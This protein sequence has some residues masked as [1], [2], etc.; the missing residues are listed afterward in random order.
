MK[1]PFKSGPSL[2]VLAAAAGLPLLGAWAAGRNLAPILRFPPNLAMPGGAPPFAWAWAAA[3]AAV[4]A[5]IAASWARAPRL[6]KAPMARAAGAR[7]PFPA[8][9][10]AALG[11]TGLAWILAWTRWT[12]FAP[13]Q[14]YTFFPLWLGFVVS[15]NAAT[16]R[17]TGRCLMLRRPRTWLALFAVSAGFWW[18]FEWLN[19][20]VD[21]WRYLGVERFGPAAYAFHATLCF[22][23]V[24]PAV[25]A[26]AEWLGSHP[27]WTARCAAGPAWTWLA[28]RDA[29]WLLLL[30]GI[31]A[32][33]FTGARPRQAYPALWTAPLA[34]ALGEG[35]LSRRPGTASEL[36]SGDWRRAGTW[37]A[38]ALLCGGFWE[39]WN[40]GSLAHWAYAVPYVD[41]WHLFA[42]PALG[43][44]GYLPFGLECLEICDRV[45]GR[46]RLEDA[47]PPSGG[48][49][50]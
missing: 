11:W 28:R 8:W 9:G 14:A 47:C 3:V 22:S 19:R 50:V 38:A 10:W 5:A 40:F 46:D 17:R 24:L 16:W 6:R 37:A 35:I 2:A 20:F 31:A 13:A 39:C 41:R 33:V 15:V 36:A 45:F 29:G 12:W 1:P 42:M 49:P 34:L 18:L 23:T 4:P 48:R 21:N 26:V 44:V 27:R 30:A 32:L 25:A 7:R 43:Y